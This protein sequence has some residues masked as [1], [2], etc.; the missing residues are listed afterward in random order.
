MNVLDKTPKNEFMLM[1]LNEQKYI[2]HLEK[3]KK[4]AGTENICYICLRKPYKDTLNDLK[5]MQVNTDAFVF[6]DVLSSHYKKRKDTHNCVFL[7]SPTD[8]NALLN[9]IETVTKSRKCPSLVLDSISAL[10]MY[11]EIFP[12]LTFT[13]SLITGEMGCMKK[14]FLVIKN[15]EIPDEASNELIKDLGMLADNTIFL[16]GCINKTDEYSLI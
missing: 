8:L 15:D 4:S 5:E 14:I 12:I 1:V 11:R 7:E 16:N 9:T 2:N 3:I 13:N 10:L 6:I